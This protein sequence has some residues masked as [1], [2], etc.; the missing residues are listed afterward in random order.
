M[1]YDARQ[2]LKDKLSDN[3]RESMTI[4]GR[5]IYTIERKKRITVKPILHY[6]FGLR[7]GNVCEHK[8]EKTQEKYKK[9]T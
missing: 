1:T 7:F 3:S 6:A 5:E 4:M 2:R 9:N 8:R